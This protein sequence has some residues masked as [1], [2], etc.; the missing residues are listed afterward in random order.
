MQGVSPRNEKQRS[1][2]TGLDGG[3]EKKTEKGSVQITIADI[4]YISKH[5][6]NTN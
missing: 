5:D 3:G 4:D 6:A 2:Q 1:D